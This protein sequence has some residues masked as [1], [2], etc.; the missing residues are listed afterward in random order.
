MNSPVYPEIDDKEKAGMCYAKAKYILAIF[1]YNFRELD[2]RSH[3][4]SR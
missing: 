1:L 4:K 3:D 2:L